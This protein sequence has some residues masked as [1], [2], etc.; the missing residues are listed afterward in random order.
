MEART[1]AVSWIAREKGSIVGIG[2]LDPPKPPEPAPL[3]LHHEAAQRFWTV[4]LHAKGT[5][6]IGALTESLAALD[7][8]ERELMLRHYGLR[9]GQRVRLEE[10]DGTGKGFYLNKKVLNS[11]L[12]V[13]RKEFGQVSGSDL[14]TEEQRAREERRT[15]AAR[16]DQLVKETR[17]SLFRV[18]LAIG[19]RQPI[20]PAERVL[21]RLEE[22]VRDLVPKPKS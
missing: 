8:S 12:H 10:A 9:D 11:A 13:L 5:V 7:E 18:H 3:V 22:I 15:R 19:Q 17:N 14:P 4:N 1:V 6:K 21:E 16:F 2:P 20:E